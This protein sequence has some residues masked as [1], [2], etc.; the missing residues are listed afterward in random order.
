M[1]WLAGAWAVFR[2]DFELEMRLRSLR[3]ISS[4]LPVLALIYAATIVQFLI[5]PPYVPAQP[6]IMVAGV[7]ATLTLILWGAVNPDEPR[8]DTAVTLNEPLM[9]FLGTNDQ[10]GD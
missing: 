3:A 6:Y 2:K 7:F 5:A 8:L 1:A 4:V 10:P 9:W